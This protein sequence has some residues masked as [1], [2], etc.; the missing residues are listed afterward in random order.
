MYILYKIMCFG[1]NYTDAC[2]LPFNVSKK[3]KNWWMD[4]RI[5]RYTYKVNVNIVNILSIVKF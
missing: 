3:K 1:M 4:K 5:I 2:C